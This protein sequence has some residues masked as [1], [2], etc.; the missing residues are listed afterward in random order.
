[1]INRDIGIDRQQNEMKRVQSTLQKQIDE[2][3]SEAKQIRHQNEIA[4][5]SLQKK[6]EE[7]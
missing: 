5:K 1:M 3:H 6:L 4:A 7:V 2:L